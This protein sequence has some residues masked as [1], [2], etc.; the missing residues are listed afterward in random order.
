M[1][2][3]DMWRRQQQ[4]KVLHA[5]ARCNAR[6]VTASAEHL[7]SDDEGAAHAGQTL[8]MDCVSLFKGISYL[9]NVVTRCLFLP[10]N[11]MWT[12]HAA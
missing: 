12:V 6:N 9:R 10:H 2:T 8:I 4:V 3:E 1:A 11:R 5:A 7:P